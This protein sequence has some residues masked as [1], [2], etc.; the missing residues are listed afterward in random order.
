MDRPRNPRVQKLQSA[1]D[2]FDKLLKFLQKKKRERKSF[3][4][5]KR[6]SGTNLSGVIPKKKTGFMAENEERDVRKP[7]AFLQVGRCT[8]KSTFPFQSFPRESEPRKK[9]EKLY[10]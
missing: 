6:N 7:S 1:Q 5:S 4:L 3:R 9:M 2:F 10:S 8:P